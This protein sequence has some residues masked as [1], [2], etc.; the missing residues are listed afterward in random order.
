MQT[1]TKKDN[2]KLWV[3]KTNLISEEQG[4]LDNLYTTVKSDVVSSIN[5]VFTMLNT[6]LSDVVEDQSPELGN[7]LN[8][9]THSI[10]GTG[11]INITGLYY[12]GLDGTVTTTTHANAPE[13]NSTSVA[14]TAF[15]DIAITGALALG[16]PWAGDVNG[17]SSGPILLNAGVIGMPEI[18]KTTS[19]YSGELQFFGTD[20][21]NQL[22]FINT[23]ELG[24]VGGGNLSGSIDA[25]EIL[26]NTIG[27]NELDLSDGSDGHVLTTDGSGTASFEPSIIESSISPTVGEQTFNI[28]YIVGMIVVYLNGI[29]QINGQDFTA[30]NGTSVILNSAIAIAGSTID[31]QIYGIN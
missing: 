24:A 15:N 26:P 13:N 16:I 22:T 10:T 30:D 11:D 28:N 1:V 27:I 21:S 5:E 29:K 14:T 9:N 19:Y 7:D 4:N 31:F 8:L 25:L 17:L 2:F 12:G 20:G 6:K 23:T 3:E 18:D